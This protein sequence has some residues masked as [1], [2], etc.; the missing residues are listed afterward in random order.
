[1]C[2]QFPFKNYMHF[3]E[4]KCNTG[5][6]KFQLIHLQCTVRKE[7]KLDKNPFFAVDWLNSKGL[8]TLKKGATTYCNWVQFACQ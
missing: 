3:I 8:D 1:M 4:S 7:T 5:I 6:C 2:Q